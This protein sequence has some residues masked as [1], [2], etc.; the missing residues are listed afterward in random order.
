MNSE[1]I[2]TIDPHGRAVHLADCLFNDVTQDYQSGKLGSMLQT[3]LETP[4]CM[5]V[6]PGEDCYYF[7]SLDLHCTVLVHVVYLNEKWLAVEWKKNPEP[8]YIQELLK[9]GTFITGSN[10]G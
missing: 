8:D 2:V 1:I 5:I 7:R 4:S 9:T 3:A 10:L 6:M